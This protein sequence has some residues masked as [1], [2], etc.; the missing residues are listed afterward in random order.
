[1]MTDFKFYNEKVV[2][3][4][5]LENEVRDILIAQKGHFKF[6]PNLGGGID[7]FVDAK[8][9]DLT[10]FSTISGELKKDGKRLLDA[11][12]VGDIYVTKVERS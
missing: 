4:E 2:L 11:K 8:I 12:T 7:D 3:G 9:S 5:S 6:H 10:I 1:M